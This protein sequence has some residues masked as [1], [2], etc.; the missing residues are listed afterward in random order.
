MFGCSCNT[1][2]RT[3]MSH[4]SVTKVLC[5]S[6][7]GNLLMDDEVSVNRRVVIPFRSS[8][9]K[10]QA[11]FRSSIWSSQF[12]EG[13]LRTTRV[14]NRLKTI[15]SY[16]YERSSG[17]LQGYF[18]G[19]FSLILCKAISNLRDHIPC[20]SELVVYIKEWRFLSFMVTIGF[21]W[22]I[23]TSFTY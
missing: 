6:A 21:C 17:T 19:F 5:P 23:G 10:Y 12:S 14:T 16:K 4:A 11:L 13:T 3:C 7:L 9:F 8:L 18:S 22:N 15:Q 1:I 2:Q 20:L